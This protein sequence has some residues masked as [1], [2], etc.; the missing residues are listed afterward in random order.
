MKNDEEIKRWSTDLCR[1]WA[2]RDGWAGT[3][4]RLPYP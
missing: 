2:G 3:G 4:H 1:I